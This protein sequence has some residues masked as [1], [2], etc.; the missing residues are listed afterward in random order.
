MINR[1][2][3][4]VDQRRAVVLSASV[5]SG[6]NRAGQAIQRAL[7]KIRPNWTVEFVDVL[8][9]TNST[10]RH[11]Y[12]TGYFDLIARAPHLVGYLYDRL[13]RPVRRRAADRVRAKF[14][15]W[16]FTRLIDRLID[17]AWDLA[18]CTHFLPAEILAELRRTGRINFPQAVVTTDFDA[19]RLWV[20][21]PCE[22][23]FTATEEG[24]ANLAGYGVPLEQIFTTGIPIDPGFADWKSPAEC[25][26]LQG[27]TGD[28][29]VVLQLS[30]GSG[31]GPVEEVHRRIL[32][33]PVP[34][35]LIA[36]AGRNSALRRRLEEISC[37]S[38]HRRKIIGFTDQMNELMGAADLVV[39]KPGGLSM[40]ESLACG[41]AMLLI[42]PIP[43][44]EM[45]NSDY[46]LENG[47]AIKVN[48]LSSLSFKL[49]TVL[50][51][52]RR[53]DGMRGNAKRLARPHAAFDVAE[54]CTAMIDQREDLPRSNTIR[55]QRVGV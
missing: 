28:R 13:D 23:Y 24:R 17:G 43:G 5:G 40:S 33:S 45:R 48:N 50:S 4:I 9:L 22:Q 10:F 52:P 27:L 15:L 26:R 18:V 20:N 37:S 32:Q 16:N 42:D 11:A 2:R 34:L 19:H 39:S 44:Q 12:G 35:Q 31:F 54:K 53:L 3:S 47:A 8:E 21:A 49:T 7:R 36:V 29:P 25:R 46:L 41:A 30:G 51:E 1:I 6:H 55:R 14:Q 38:R